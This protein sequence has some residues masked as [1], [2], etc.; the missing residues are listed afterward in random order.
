MELHIK[1]MVCDRCIMVVRER[2]ELEGFEVAK[3]DLGTAAISPE[4]DQQELLNIKASLNAVGFDL[5]DDEKSKLV[6]RMK[7]IIIELVHHSEV[8]QEQGN[9]QKQL[10][11]RLFKEYSQLSRTFSDHE[12]FTVEKFVIQQKIE[13]AK[14]L[15]QE[16]ELNLNEIAWHLGYSSS[17]HLSSQFKTLTGSSPREYKAQESKDRKP[18]DK[19]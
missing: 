19:I 12:G 1:N 10:S 14:A 3:I 6:E 2:L 5:I 13:K 4:P 7:N 15:L 17:S 8:L 11:S 16:G 18:L 9:I